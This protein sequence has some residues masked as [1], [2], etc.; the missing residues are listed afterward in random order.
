MPKNPYDWSKPKSKIEDKL[1][2]IDNPPEIN[3]NNNLFFTPY[4]QA[5][6]EISNLIKD[7][8]ESGQ[9]KNECVEEVFLQFKLNVLKNLPDKIKVRKKIDGGE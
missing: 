9:D 6:Q 1:E 3:T 2:E 8:V 4:Y 5:V 7:K